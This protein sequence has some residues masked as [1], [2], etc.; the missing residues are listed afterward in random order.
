MNA[1][2]FRTIAAAAIVLSLAAAGVAIQPV[3]TPAAKPAQPESRQPASK[4]PEQVPGQKREPGAE[5]RRG[6]GLG[7]GGSMKLMD[8]SLEKLRGQIGDAAKRDE[9]LR[10]INEVQR[11][12]VTAKGQPLPPDVLKKAADDTAKTKLSETFRKELIA[13]V[14]KLLDI[15]TEIADGK[16]DAART[17]L[18]EAMKIGEAAHRALGLGEE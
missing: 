9:N 13:F 15:E 17:H 12:A 3:G 6:E 11:G 7:L 8:R 4:Q 2:N 14:R 10:L 1:S 18:E 16:T 5:G